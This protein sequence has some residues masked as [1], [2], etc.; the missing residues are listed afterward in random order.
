[1][2]KCLRCGKEV[3]SLVAGSIRCPGC[4]Y[5]IFS[6]TREPITKTIRAR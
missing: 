6:K 1:M 4:G 2:Y 5:K 3:Q